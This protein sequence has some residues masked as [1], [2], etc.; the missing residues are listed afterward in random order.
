MAVD[1]RFSAVE[2]QLSGGSTDR[3]GS[4]SVMRG[5]GRDRPEVDVSSLVLTRTLLAFP[6]NA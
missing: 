4:N 3:S 1:G 2:W 6:D 5:L